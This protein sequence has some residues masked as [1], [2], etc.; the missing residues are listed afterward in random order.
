MHGLMEVNKNMGIRIST[1]LRIV[2]ILGKEGIECIRK[3]YI[4]DFKYTCHDLKFFHVKN[5]S[6][7]IKISKGA[8][9][10]R[11]ILLLE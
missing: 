5:Y 11:N 9:E 10:L 1:K 3:E 4:G 8:K 2:V 6:I 7:F